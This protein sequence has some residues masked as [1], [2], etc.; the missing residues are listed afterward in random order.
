MLPDQ[1]IISLLLVLLLCHMFERPY[2]VTS[3]AS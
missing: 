2:S 3:T 1:G